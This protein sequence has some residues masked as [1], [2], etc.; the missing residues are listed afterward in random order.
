M[1]GKNNIKE[2]LEQQPEIPPPQK[3]EKT[4]VSWYKNATN[5]RRICVKNAVGFL[6][7]STC[8]HNWLR[9]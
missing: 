7:L 8:L 4:Q 1:V 3:K 9:L 6:K 2:I 5:E